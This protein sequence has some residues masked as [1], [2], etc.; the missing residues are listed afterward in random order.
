MAT[1]KNTI[2]NWFLT[3]FK[4]TQLQFWALF[5]SYFHKDEKIPITAIDSI[6]IIL[7]AKADA[8]A[9]TNHVGDASAHTTLFNAK[10]DKAQKG[11]AGGYVPLDNFSKIMSQYL[12]IIDDLV[13]GGSTNLASAETVKT[14]KGL[15]DGITVLSAT[16]TVLGIVKLAGD[17][18][19]TADLPTTPT[20]VHKTGN[21]TIIG[22]I[23]YDRTNA[24][25]DAVAS[26]LSLL[27]KRYIY[28]E[29][30]MSVKFPYN[31]NNNFLGTIIGH[32]AGKFSTV[33]SAVLLGWSAGERLIA[34][35]AGNSFVGVGKWALHSAYGSFLTAVGDDS[36]KF[37]RGNSNVYYGE[38][39]GQVSI[40]N[41]CVGIGTDALK[42]NE[43]DNNIQISS[44]DE[45]FNTNTA[46][47]KSYVP[48]NISGNQI[49]LTAHG[50]GATDS[51]INM[52]VLSATVEG[53]LIIGQVYMFKIISANIIEKVVDFSGYD[54]LIGTENGVIAPQF[55]YNNTVAIG[56]GAIQRIN[57]S[58][59]IVLG[60][61]QIEAVKAT[62]FE[63]EWSDYIKVNHSGNQLTS[64]GVPYE[65][66]VGSALNTAATFTNNLTSVN[67]LVVSNGSYQSGIGNTITPI[68]INTGNGFIFTSVCGSSLLPTT[69]SLNIGICV[70][71]SL[72][73]ST[74]A[75]AIGFY[76]DS[77]VTPRTI[78]F[79]CKGVSVGEDVSTGIVFSTTELYEFYI[80][81]DPNSNDVIWRISS[82]S[83]TTK[84]LLASGSV[85]KLVGYPANNVVGLM[86][87][88]IWVYNNVATANLVKVD[89]R[90]MNIKQRY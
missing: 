80:K 49:T 77:N 58:N 25:I 17:L 59:Q 55:R 62:S 68:P 75:N 86:I 63:P 31:S 78:R 19:G 67:R 65:A 82:L 27:N 40:G 48:A 6:E 16:D 54:S 32:N 53:A 38:D 84:T 52:K 8:E 35:V 23:G 28:D 30:Q 72:T 90:S 42:N 37:Q 56:N 51:Y 81:F 45:N 71:S 50:L 74:L 24:Q 89:F 10:E 43:G 14:L 66:A 33:Q 47:Q 4:P 3:N 57:G 18:G 85:S 1:D 13:T 70:S 83:P 2:K 41:S 39:S 12:M 29:A 36:G 88:P 22:D 73:P 61:S 20:A 87:F 60:N 9:L 11:V 76:I 26:G 15:I 64:F 21:E 5:D 46:S 79:R 34:D 44:N 69:A 7:N